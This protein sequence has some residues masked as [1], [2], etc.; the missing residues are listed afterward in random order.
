MPTT[1]RS[2][3]TPSD[4]AMR[5]TPERGDQTAEGGP[6]AEAVSN[7]IDR[8]DLRLELHWETH[9]VTG[10][11][12]RELANHRLRDYKAIIQW[13][14][15]AGQSYFG[16]VLDLV[17]LFARLQEL[18]VLSDVERRCVSCACVVHD[19]NKVPPYNRWSGGRHTYADQASEANVATELERIEAE[20]FF[21]AWRDYLA[22]I[23]ALAH[24]HQ[25]NLAITATGLDRTQHRR[26]KLGWER[27]QRLGWLMYAVDTLAT[28]HT[29]VETRSKANALDKINLFLANRPHR[30]LT[31]R[32][33]EQRGLLTN[34]I[35]NAA[36][37]QLRAAAHAVDL[38]YYPDGVA[39][40][41]PSESPFVWNADHMASVA[42]RVRHRVAS[43]QQEDV[44]KF[45]RNA[46]W[47]I[48]VD[49][50]ALESGALSADVFGV[51]FSRV[52]AKPYKADW[53][54]QRTADITADLEAALSTGKL[55]AASRAYV[56]ER[57]AT[58]TI[59]PAEPQMLR[60]GELAM[61]Y[62]NYLNAHATT[63][64]KAAKVRNGETRVYALLGLPEARWPAYGAVNAYRWGYFLASDCALSLDDLHGAIL[65]DLAHLHS[66]NAE[67]IPAA[68]RTV[69]P[70][71]LD[72]YL[73]E[74]LDVS[75]TAVPAAHY[76]AHLRR[77]VNGEH[78]QCCV[79]SGAAP[80]QEWMAANAPPS[81]A[82]QVFSNRLAGGDS[83]E[84]KRNI[85]PVCRTQFILERLA[86]KS[87]RDKQ[88]TEQTTFYLHLFPYSFFTRSLLTAWYAEVQR[89]RSQDL[90]SFFIK[91]DAVF[92][93]WV[94]GDSIAIQGVAGGTMGVAL[95]ELAEALGNTPVLPI[96]ARGQGYGE[97]FLQALETAVILAR[98][99]G[100][101]A[102]LSRLP[103]PILDLSTT[104]DVALCV[105]G[106]PRNLGWLFSGTADSTLGASSA[107]NAAALQGLFERLGHLH[108][109]KQRLWFAG[110]SGDM[111]H[112][113]ATAMQD[114]ALG[115][116]AAADRLLEK[117]VAKGGKGSPEWQA[118]HHVHDLAPHLQALVTAQR[119]H[120]PAKKGR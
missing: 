89:L 69:E 72:R 94:A 95:P 68:P 83:R 82:V 31:H 5:S 21:P 33:A 24:L 45:I 92:R 107:L 18:L 37:A 26:L 27:I 108:A 49:S 14:G 84:P 70:S 103:V 23:V 9:D 39:Y 74:A 12:F 19:L 88:G 109:L 114:D 64:L 59:I 86:W 71:A 119:S 62:R 48:A 96:H 11:F 10:D 13:G 4:T 54:V 102:L 53:L 17:L 91:A 77:Y 42:A 25:G 112:A 97:Q 111:V 1:R 75:G 116:Y 38:L 120:A 85:C 7:V 58:G 104:P 100:C 57:L 76:A 117:K 30:W 29:L 65:A 8:A 115:I 81:I 61:A 98:F 67:T 43:L 56:V 28:S 60:L 47:G 3:K 113:L 40:L 87:H 99:F 90:G 110:F 50:A 36:V 46:P 6:P 51:I 78:R 16:H 2:L 20:R 41:V 35:H 80:A 34:L 105:E 32:V 79:C 66:E 15:K 118:I 93:D 106:M 63:L 52:Q 101:R 55:D 44:G 22:D 73:Q